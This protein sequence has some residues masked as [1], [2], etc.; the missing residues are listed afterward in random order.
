MVCGVLYKIVDF[1]FNIKSSNDYFNK[2]IICEASSVPILSWAS[3]LLLQCGVKGNLDALSFQVL[4]RFQKH[5]SLRIML[6][7]V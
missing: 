3:Q 5:L 7:A 2:L 6:S 1:L 4:V